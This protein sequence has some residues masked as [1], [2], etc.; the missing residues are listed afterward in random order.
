M[1]TW[2]SGWMEWVSVVIFWSAKVSRCFTR[3]RPGWSTRLPFLTTMLPTQ[4]NSYH[5][6]HIS[7]STQQ[8]QPHNNS[9]FTFWLGIKVK[10]WAPPIG[11]SPVIAASFAAPAAAVGQEGGGLPASLE[12]PIPTNHPPTRLSQCFKLCLS[13]RCTLTT[14]R[15]AASCIFILS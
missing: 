3:W 14:T 4:L 12:P 7:N 8:T 6:S 13:W 10:R 9:C 15:R 2:V 5:Q 11:S 1:V